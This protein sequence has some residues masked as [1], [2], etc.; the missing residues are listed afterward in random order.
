M[1]P[2][3]TPVTTKIQLIKISKLPAETTNFGNQDR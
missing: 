1:E 3:D 2:E